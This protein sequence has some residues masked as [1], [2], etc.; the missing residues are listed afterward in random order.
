[1]EKVHWSIQ[2][3][4]ILF[5]IRCRSGYSENYYG[6]YNNAPENRPCFTTFTGD[7]L[8]YFCIANVL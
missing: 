5:P 7:R 3:W 2:D 6:R 8:Q 4:R 1:M